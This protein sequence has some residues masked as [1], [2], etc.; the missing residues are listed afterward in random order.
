MH[1]RLPHLLLP[2]VGFLLLWGWFSWGVS[3][4]GL[5]YYDEAY[6]VLE[7]RWVAGGAQLAGGYAMAK[8]TGS[9]PSLREYVRARGG[10]PFGY[11][12]SYGKPTHT[13]ILAAG[14]LAAGGASWGAQA[15]VGFCGALGVIALFFWAR[16][17]FGARVAFYSAFTLATSAYWSMYARETL[18]EADSVALLILGLW[19]ITAFAR[20]RGA[21]GAGG[22]ALRDRLA[23]IGA[24]TLVGLAFTANYRWFWMPLIA[25]V[26]LW[27]SP[28]ARRTDARAFASQAVWLALGMAL[29]LVVAE[30]PG[31]ALRAYYRR[32]QLAPPFE[33]YFE[34]LARLYFFH[35][36]SD[37]GFHLSGAPV[38]LYLYLRWTSPLACVAAVSGALHLLRR[39]RLGPRMAALLV[40]VP[41]AILGFYSVYTYNFARFG[42]I[43]LPFF[44]L[45]AGLGLTRWITGVRRSVPRVLPP[46]AVPVLSAVLIAIFSARNIAPALAA[47]GL[48][49]PWPAIARQLGES[50]ATR[51]VILTSELHLLRAS[52][53]PSEARTARIVQVPAG[54]A[55]REDLLRLARAAAPAA[56]RVWV[57]RGALADYWGRT[58]AFEDL[59]AA[60][61]PVR[62]WPD[63][64]TG[65]E[66]FDFEHARDFLAA[67]SGSLFSNARTI[68]VWR[69]D[70]G[71]RASSTSA[72]P[73][74]MTSHPAQPAPPETTRT[75]P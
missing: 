31:L 60:T 3:G 65:H 56:T 71:P 35:T 25:L 45:L 66:Q 47:R 17:L 20:G 36:T 11:Y 39:R 46:V 50:G 10:R 8:L 18:A 44:A 63:P 38:Y 1:R 30:L 57:V 53:A 29:P 19:A 69:L 33:T 49:S 34:Q 72:L 7:A 32:I 15:A 21:R 75:R 42:T 12:P 48:V 51:E 55:T 43:A 27:A 52:L 61:P 68:D 40:G 41:V 23:L 2:L 22:L 70:V 13:L 9:A 67:R 73:S 14:M 28:R 4:R 24:G 54:A 16:R 26:A 5:I 37:K 64:R 58:P 6:N 62:S 74:P 59:R